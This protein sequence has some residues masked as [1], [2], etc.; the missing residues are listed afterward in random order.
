MAK[1]FIG[2][3][4][5]LFPFAVFFVLRMMVMEELAFLLEIDMGTEDNRRFAREKVRPGVAYLKSEDY[6]ARF[7]VDYGR[8]LV[9][10]TSQTRLD[11]MKN[12]TNHVGGS[13]LFYFTTFDKVSLETV[14]IRPIWQL[15]GSDEVRS[16]IPEMTQIILG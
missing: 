1:A 6:R 14:L 5:I 3:L 2:L 16:I 13:G 11:N 8:W 7:G 12:Q 4:I 9:V 10:T 15:A